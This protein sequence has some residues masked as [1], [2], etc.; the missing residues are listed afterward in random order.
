[1]QRQADLYE[2]EVSLVYIVSSRTPELY[3]EVDPVLKQNI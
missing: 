1:M 3:S 2:F